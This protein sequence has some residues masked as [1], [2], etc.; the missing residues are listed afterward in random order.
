MNSD[1][2]V[3]VIGGGPAGATAAA[4]L[5]AR[6]HRVLLAEKEHFPSFH[7][8]ES[9][10]PMALPVLDEV[11]VVLDGTH[12][13]YKQ[14]A[15]F[16]DERTGQRTFFSFA[17]A[18][19]G[20]PDHAYQVERSVFDQQLLDAAR[21][22]GAEVHLGERVRRAT[23]AEHGV[24]V[25][26]ASGVAR[27]RYLVDASGRD[28]FL[29]ARDRT[30]DK[31][32]GLGRGASFT[33]YEGLS[34]SVAA[35]LSAQGNVK[36]VRV[37]RGWVWVI[38]LAGRRLSV[39]AVVRAGPVRAGFVEEV[40][41]SSPLLQRLTR[42]ARRTE[43]RVCGDYSYRNRLPYRARGVCVGDA[44]CFLDPVFSSGVTL[45]LQSA[46]RMVALL[47]PALA[48]GRESDP[49]L[50]GPLS[51]QL[52]V[53][54]AGFYALIDRFYNT[55]I[56][57]NLFFAEAP[58]PDGRRGLISLLAGDVWRDDNP[59]QDMILRGS[60][61]PVPVPEWASPP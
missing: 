27:C 55:N 20:S 7:I 59:F 38:P 40:V 13:Q 44:A 15:E 29:G 4:L 58:D 19:R 17:D 14:G 3:F 45:A 52:R 57:D 35:E 25:E 2:E 1:C 32:D 47:S 8:G 12:H 23:F 9:L 60:R 5:A 50:M 39:G 22:A 56:V 16:L 30:V 43:L 31:L 41:A 6:G 49:E 21:D 53:A 48:R 18:L 26:T 28:L 42:G 33:H 46:S 61:R 11:G 24:T 36:I 51:A 54:Y 34:A 37:E 10:L